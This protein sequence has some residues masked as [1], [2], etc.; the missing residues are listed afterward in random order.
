MA[1]DN[2]GILGLRSFFV[3]YCGFSTLTILIYQY[4]NNAPIMRPRSYLSLIDCIKLT[5]IRVLEIS[6]VPGGRKGLVRCRRV[7][8]RGPSHLGWIVKSPKPMAAPH[9]NLRHPPH[10]N[11]THDCQIL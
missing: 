2:M 11:P 4:F 5:R 7:N 6:A 8:A 1:G 10:A 9:T 3:K